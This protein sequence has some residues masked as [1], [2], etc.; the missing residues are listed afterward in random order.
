MKNT[1]RKAALALRA[2]LFLLK[3]IFL[4][5]KKRAIEYLS[6]LLTTEITEHTENRIKIIED[7]Q[8]LI[9]PLWSLCPLW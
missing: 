3:K 6:S 4:S 5:D 2:R 9:L 8:L 7:V 1:F